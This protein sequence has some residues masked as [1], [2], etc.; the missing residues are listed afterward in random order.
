[1]SVSPGRPRIIKVLEGAMARVVTL[2]FGEKDNEPI[3]GVFV[4]VCGPV[5]LRDEVVRTVGC[6]DAKKR[7]A[8]GGVE[9]YEE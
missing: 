7:D 9:I 3:T 8:V 2:G 4:G 6:V 1:M 5:G